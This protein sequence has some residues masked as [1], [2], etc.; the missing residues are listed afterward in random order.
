MIH[1]GYIVLPQ[2]HDGLAPR[3]A[4]DE[5]LSADL[6]AQFF[7]EAWNCQKGDIALTNGHL[8]LP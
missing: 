3:S 6:L 5:K 7:H 8:P 2:A 1:R 4:S